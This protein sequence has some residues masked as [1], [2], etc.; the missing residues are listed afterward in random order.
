MPD[1]QNNENTHVEN[2]NAYLY[3]PNRPDKNTSSPNC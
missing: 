2:A 3:N 1:E